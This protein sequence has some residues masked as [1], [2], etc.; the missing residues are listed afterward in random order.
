MAVSQ[1]LAILATTGWLRSILD[2]PQVYVEVN[3]FATK[4]ETPELGSKGELAWVEP[5]AAPSTSKKFHGS[6]T[7]EP[8]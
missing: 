4:T 7:M 1:L 8:P 2:T 3:H 6:N 5:E